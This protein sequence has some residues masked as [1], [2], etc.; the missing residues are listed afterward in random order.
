MLFRSHHY[1]LDYTTRVAQEQVASVCFE[2]RSHPVRE[3]LEA[4]QWD[5][6]PRLDSFLA[7]C[8]GIDL[9]P[10]ATVAVGRSTAE[11]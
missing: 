7:D 10:G 4:Q 2:C 5:G 11:T 9:I 3:Y 8:F 1:H 6:T